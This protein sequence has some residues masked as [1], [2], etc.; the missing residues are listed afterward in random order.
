MDHENNWHWPPPSK[1]KGPAD[2]SDNGP[3]E[4]LQSLPIGQDLEQKRYRVIDDDQSSIKVHPVAT[5]LRGRIAE[6]RE[7]ST[8]V[9]GEGFFIGLIC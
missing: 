7:L 5:T 9:A 2:G 6:F 8:Q 1:K 3:L 4:D